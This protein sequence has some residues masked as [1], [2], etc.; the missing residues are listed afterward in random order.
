M[1]TDVT[2]L[3]DPYSA[4]IW[5]YTDRSLRKEGTATKKYKHI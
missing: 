2:C 3:S 1:N 5:C 4:T